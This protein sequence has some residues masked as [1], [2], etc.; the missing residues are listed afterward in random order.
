MCTLTWRRFA[1]AGESHG[2]YELFFNRDEKRT[3][4]PELPP[5]VRRAGRGLAV[6]PRDSDGGGTWISGND[7]GVS[8]A[9]LNGYRESDAARGSF[10]S[11]GLLVTRLSSE[12]D[13]DGVLRVLAAL[14]LASFRSFTLVAFDTHAAPSVATWDGA[15]LSVDR[16][17][18]SHAAFVTSSSFS[19]PLVT[20][21]RRAA[22]DALSENG[23]SA[24]LLALHRGHAFGASAWSVCMHR[25]D[26][27]TRSLTR[28]R[29]DDGALRLDWHAGPPCR[30][31]AA[32]VTKIPLAV[33][34]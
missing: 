3:R 6:S 20:A 11:R 17:S 33:R 19:A 22:F 16:A 23:R 27:E 10:E 14:D 9:L 32:L 8:L 34:V 2:G 18:D 5:L 30:R 1:R 13:Q 24:R 15:R 25:P 21:R 7:R 4:G 28:I 26:A 29:V 31:E 12:D